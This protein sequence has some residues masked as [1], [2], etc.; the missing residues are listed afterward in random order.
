[1]G[2]LGP[3]G[4]PDVVGVLDQRGPHLLAVD[5]PLAVLQARLGLKAGEVGSRTG[6]GVADREVHLALEDL[7]EN[8]FL[9]GV[10]AEPHD[11]RADGVQGQVRDGD[12]GV[13]SFIGEDQLLDHRAVL[14]TELLGPPDPEPAV[15]ADLLDDVLVD[16]RVAELAAAGYDAFCST[17]SELAGRDQV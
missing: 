10:V 8:L 11:G 2:G 9:L 4:E 16:G 3:G 17:L 6:L 1:V 5:D 14:A 13:R 12:A 15:V 7:G